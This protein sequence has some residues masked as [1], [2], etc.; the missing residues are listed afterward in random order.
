MLKK[1]HG[2]LLRKEIEKMLKYDRKMVINK[3]NLLRRILSPLESFYI[4]KRDHP[5]MPFNVSWLEGHRT[6]VDGSVD[7]KY[8]PKVR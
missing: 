6:S 5:N 2:N 1:V 7:F 4:L 3:Y 8:I